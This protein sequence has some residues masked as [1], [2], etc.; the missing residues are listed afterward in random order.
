MLSATGFMAIITYGLVLLLPLRG[1]EQSFFTTFPSF[2]FIAVVSMI[3]YTWICNM[4]K[5]EETKPVI[6]YIRRL[7]FGRTKRT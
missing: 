1:G 5:L 3:G 2:T 6:G 7:L 4:L